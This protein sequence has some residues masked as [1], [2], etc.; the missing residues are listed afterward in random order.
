MASIGMSAEEVKTR[1]PGG[2]EFARYNAAQKFIVSGELNVVTMF[3]K[4]HKDERNLAVIRCQ[5]LWHC[6]S[7]S[8]FSRCGRF[9]EEVCRGRLL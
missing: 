6:S 7:H 9:T 8:T 1:L 4:Q 3:G 5:L 2:V